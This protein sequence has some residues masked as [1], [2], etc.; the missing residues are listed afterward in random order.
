M[1]RWGEEEKKSKGLFGCAFAFALLGLTLYVF[2]INYTNLEGR[3]QLEKAMQ[4]SVRT[5]YD[6][7]E[8]VMMG[9]ILTAAENLGLDIQSEDIDLQKFYDDNNNPVVDVRIDFKFTVDMLVFQFE[10]EIP[11]VEKVTIV[12]F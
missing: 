4:E 10:V 11:I 1:G 3:R 9:E 6:K 2:F 5:G 12:I 7:T 8:Q